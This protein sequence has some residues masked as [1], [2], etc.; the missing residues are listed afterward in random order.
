MHALCQEAAMIPIRELGGLV[1]TIKKNEVIIIYT[2]LPAIFKLYICID[3]VGIF[4][5]AITV[6]DC[7]LHSLH[8]IPSH[9]ADAQWGEMSVMK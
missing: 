1:S 5:E 2:F 8:T 7:Q 3:E 6:R 9:Y 4:L